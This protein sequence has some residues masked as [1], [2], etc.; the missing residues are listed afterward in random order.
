MTE[1]H[2]V[3]KGALGARVRAFRKMRK[4]SVRGLADLAQVSPAFVSRIE[5]GKANAS[6][7]VVRRLAT[8]LGLTLADLFE[9]AGAPTGKVLKREQRPQLTTG[10]DVRN[11][12]ITRPPLRD[13]EVIVS[14]YEPA[15]S[16]GD[17]R[18]THGDSQEIV[19]VTKGT[20]SFELDGEAF[21]MHEGDSLDFR[22]SMPHMITNIGDCLGEAVWVVSP[23]SAP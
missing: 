15:A 22:S 19:L 1:T 11:Y 10:S 9:P 18:Y 8:S 23:P 5:N 20:F 16:S 6:F 2:Q 13:V 17:Y 14:E 7:D 3:G 12:S 4:I 21:T